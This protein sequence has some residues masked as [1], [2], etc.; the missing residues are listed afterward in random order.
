V[1][2]AS[3]GLKCLGTHS[4][5]AVLH[6]PYPTLHCDVCRV[7]TC[8]KGRPA[9]PRLTPTLFPF[10]AVLSI[11][12]VLCLSHR[13]PVSFETCK[14]LPHVS[15]A[16]SLPQAPFLPCAS[17]QFMVCT[18]VIHYYSLRLFYAVFHT[19]PSLLSL[20]SYPPSSHSFPILIFSTICLGGT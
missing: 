17:C 16:D 14:P 15:P 4:V 10:E 11:P 18:C 9:L 19:S 2:Q 3:S 1:S 12:L 5:L 8:E 20:S 6:A 13:Q 7:L